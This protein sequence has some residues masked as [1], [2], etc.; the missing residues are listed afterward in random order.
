MAPIARK[1]IGLR[2]YTWA[3][4]IIAALFIAAAAY[5]F[6]KPVAAGGTE[7]TFDDFT[8][9]SNVNLITAVAYTFYAVV[10]GVVYGL[11]RLVL[12]LWVHYR[13]TSG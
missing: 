5:Y 1:R 13:K 4:I 8:C 2:I 3:T 10:V 6:L 12:W 11:A 7:C 9:E